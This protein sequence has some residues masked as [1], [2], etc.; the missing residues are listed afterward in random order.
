MALWETGDGAPPR[1]MAVTWPGI[2]IIT[3]VHVYYGSCCL[4]EISIIGI[5]CVR[6]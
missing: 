4:A 6:R 3:C 5:M 2:H 1:E